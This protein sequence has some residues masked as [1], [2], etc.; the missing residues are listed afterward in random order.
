MAIHPEIWR[1]PSGI[2]PE[3]IASNPSGGLVNITFDGVGILSLS[4]MSVAENM[5][6]PTEILINGV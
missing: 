5:A 6:P 2:G 3:A 4:V 1:I